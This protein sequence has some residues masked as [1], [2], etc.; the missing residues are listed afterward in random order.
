MYIGATLSDDTPGPLYGP[1]IPLA[2]LSR[3][4]GPR[5]LLLVWS[6]D[7]ARTCRLPVRGTVVVGRAPEAE[8]RIDSA[9]VSRQHARI[10]VEP[11][12]VQLVDLGSQNGTRVNGERLNGERPLV[13]GDLL[14][15]GDVTCTLVADQGDAAAGAGAGAETAV[16]DGEKRIDLGDRAVV[17]AD[18]AMRHVYTQLERLAPS[19][20][21]VLILGET[22]TGKELAAA[23]VRFWSRRR[24]KPLVAINCAALPDTLAESELFGYERGAFS[25]AAAAKPGLLE[26]A[27]GGTVFL[28]E[29]GDLSLAVQAKLLRVLEA[30]RLT[31]LGSVTE[32]PIDV[33][34][35]AATHRDLAAEVRAGRFREDLFYRLSVGVVRLPPLRARPRELP[36]L[37]RRFLDEATTAQGRA[38]LS[39]GES[40]VARLRAHPF[41]GNVRELKNLM[42][43]VAA[44]VIEPVVGPEHLE[45][46][47][48]SP[49]DDPAPGAGSPA[50]GAGAPFRPLGEA[51][52]DFERQ[53][54]AAALAATGGNKTAAAKLL[55]VP[56]RTLMD[57]IKR[58]GL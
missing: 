22:G 42:D 45:P 28:D 37:A 30:R 33:R 17:V 32:R 12:A 4:L 34:I 11:G 38:P 36:L 23:A 52:R 58:H 43:Y 19:E 49:G 10:S 51:N 29:V 41:P 31:R 14:T 57:K 7:A 3:P 16:D 2:D 39:L 40:A 50:A 6:A 27:P 26:S 1:T 5:H 9:A 54:I 46:R 21:S 20:L 48:G 44:T 18:P 35:V 47:L 15:F 56:L 55:G 13:Y 53:S 8:V 25:G 24:D